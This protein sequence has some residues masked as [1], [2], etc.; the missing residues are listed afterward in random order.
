MRYHI[1][2]WVA[3]LLA[4]CGCAMVQPSSKPKES[5]VFQASA[6]VHF[7]QKSWWYARFRIEWPEDAEPFWH[8]DLM[9]AH[10]VVAPVLK[11]YQDFIN[12]WRFHRRAARDQTGHQFSFIFYAGPEIADQVYN[13]LELNSVLKLMRETGLIIE[14]IYN[15]FDGNTRSEISSTSDPHWSETIRNAWPYFIM[16]TSNMW[17]HMIGD[18]SSQMADCLDTDTTTIEKLQM[19]YQKVNKTINMQWRNQGNH[20][21][22]HHLNAL[23]GYQPVVVNEKREMIF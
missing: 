5:A 14:V 17:L 21:L 8:T 19:H 9:I 13:C 22:L 6:D 18:I 4:I 12:L 20:A 1:F 10:Q 7:L 23:F 15:D 2:I 3:I 11:Q 16:G